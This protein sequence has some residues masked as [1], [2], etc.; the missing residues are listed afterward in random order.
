MKPLFKKTKQSE[1]I[2]D[3]YV[4]LKNN[5]VFRRKLQ[6]FHDVKIIQW[7]TS[8]INKAI[9]CKIDWTFYLNL[10]I[11]TSELLGAEERI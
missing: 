8:S 3:T 5:F 7:I 9:K 10:V 6:F 2:L 1:I 11:L 4:R